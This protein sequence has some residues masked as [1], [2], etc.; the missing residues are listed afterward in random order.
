MELKWVWLP[1][2]EDV[3]HADVKMCC[4]TTQLPSF[5]F[6]LWAKPHGVRGLSKHSYILLDPKLG[7][8][9]CDICKI[10]CSCVE[11][12]T[13]L[14][15]TYSPGVS[16]TEQPRYQPVFYCTYWPVLGTYNNWNIKNFTNK[17]HSLKTFMILIG[18][19]LIYLVKIWN[20]LYRHVITVPSVQKIQHQWAIILSSLFQTQINYRSK[21]HTWSVI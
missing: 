4:D 7:H 2:N 6:F 10:P 5:K 12:I 9:M 21:H 18:F 14:D 3:N 16:H 15:Y 13:M 20:C 17:L 1:K 19:S 8:G 11:Y